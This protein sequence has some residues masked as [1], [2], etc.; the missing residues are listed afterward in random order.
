M[1]AINVRRVTVPSLERG[2]QR[3]PRSYASLIWRQFRRDRVAVAGAIVLIVFFTAALFAPL[4]APYDP[5]AIDL[6][7]EANLASPSLDHLFGTD[8]AGR[9]WFS[10]A[11]F[12]ARISLSVAFA[13]VVISISIGTVVGAVSGFFGGLV[14]VILMRIVEVLMSLPL[15]FV[16]LIAQAMLPPSIF[17]LMFVIGLTSWMGVTRIVRGEVL[18]LRHLE[19]VE[20]A[21]AIGVPRYQVLIRHILPNASGPIIVAAT[22]SVAYAILTEAALSYLGLGIPLPDPS[23]G[24]MLQ[25]GLT[26]LQPAPWL[27]LFPGLMISI[28]VLA[29]NAVGD[30]LRDA[31]DPRMKDR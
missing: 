16:I 7:P 18:G 23:W 28:T 21:Q 15:F 17:T 3:A 5:N 26:R 14:D 4:V 20:A 25:K 9:D 31:F 19:Y 12:G 27:V 10:R 13:A 1:T 24:N 29:F 6:R 22:L 2:D 30:G 8:D 11:V